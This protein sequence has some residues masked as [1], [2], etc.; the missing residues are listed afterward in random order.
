M[1]GQEGDQTLTNRGKE[2]NLNLHATSWLCFMYVLKELDAFLQ[3]TGKQDFCIMQVPLS[4][5]N[6]TQL[7]D[8]SA[9]HLK[10]VRIKYSYKDCAL[11]AWKL[12]SIS[13]V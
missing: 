12:R 2:N 8:S 7:H 10:L 6:T 1:R 3:S 5:L 4:E 11:V 9:S 13:H